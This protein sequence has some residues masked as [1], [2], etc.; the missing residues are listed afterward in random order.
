MPLIYIRKSQAKTELVEE[1]GVRGEYSFKMYWTQWS[2]SLNTSQLWGFTVYWYSSPFSKRAWSQKHIVKDVY[3]VRLRTSGIES[4]IC[5]ATVM[6]VK[7]DGSLWARQWNNDLRERCVDLW[8]T[9]HSD[10]FA[11]ADPMRGSGSVRREK[12]VIFRWGPPT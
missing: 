3:T 5:V 10:L 9:I 11:V 12:F 4:G 2:K 1:T 6:P 8:L 7:I